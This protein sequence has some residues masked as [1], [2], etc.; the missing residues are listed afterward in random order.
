MDI[1]FLFEGDCFSLYLISYGND[2]VSKFIESLGKD[3]PKE[4]G[5]IITRLHQLAERGPSR[6][7]D[8]FNTLGNDLYEAK[9]KTGSRIVFFYDVN[10]I[11]ICTCGFTKKSQ[12]TPRNIIDAS[13]VKR[14]AYF[15]AKKEDMIDIVVREGNPEP[16]RKP[17]V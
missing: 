5:R 4:K 8:E 11:V 14:K 3:N 1:R 7:I 17:C 9:T 16:R 10:R 6:R 15:E 13:T 2:E 12:K